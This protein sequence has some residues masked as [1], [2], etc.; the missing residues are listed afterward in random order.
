MKKYFALALD[1]SDTTAPPKILPANDL[2][3]LKPNNDALRLKPKHDND[4][5]P[6]EEYGRRMAVNGARSVVRHKIFALNGM[7]YYG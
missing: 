5:K 4:F 1:L 2:Y 6:N 7:Y 3:A